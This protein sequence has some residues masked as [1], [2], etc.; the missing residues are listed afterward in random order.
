[1][2]LMYIVIVHMMLIVE[3]KNY[4]VEQLVLI[5]LNVDGFCR[6][7]NNYYKYNH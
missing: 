6:A 7:N 3:T 1:M 5:F 2:L 4:A